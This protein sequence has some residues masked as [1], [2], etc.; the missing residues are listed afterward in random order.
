MLVWETVWSA[1]DARTAE[2]FVTNGQSIH[3]RQIIQWLLMVQHRPD[4]PP[5]PA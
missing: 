3:R 1:H 5:C 4:E 2:I